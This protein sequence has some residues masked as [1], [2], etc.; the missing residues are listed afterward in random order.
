MVIYPAMKCYADLM[1][2]TLRFKKLRNEK[3]NHPMFVL[4]VSSRIAILCFAKVAQPCM[5][6]DPYC[7]WVRAH[8]VRTGF[9]LCGDAIDGA[10]K[11][12]TGQLK[13]VGLVAHPYTYH[14]FHY[15]R[16]CV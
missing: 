12:S 14:S 8:P 7:M 1:L 5:F 15:K 9:L 3:K 10:D 11:W 4:C 16:L 6:V 2:K 13:R